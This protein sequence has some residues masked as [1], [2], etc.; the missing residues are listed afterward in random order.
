MSNFPTRA[1]RRKRQEEDAPMSL[2]PRAFT[3][4]IVL[5]LAGSAVTA[6]ARGGGGGGAPPQACAVDLKSLCEGITPG[7][8]RIRACLI[9]HMSQLSTAWSAK[10]AR[11]AYVAKECEADVK[12]FCG[13]VKSGRNRIASCMRPHLHEVSPS[14]KGA[15][16]FIAAP[17]NR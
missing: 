6:M 17:G 11:A 5:F 12:Q 2:G 7:G 14:C 1:G 3:L 10:L 4:C 15:L 8:G 16:A 13:E 9:S